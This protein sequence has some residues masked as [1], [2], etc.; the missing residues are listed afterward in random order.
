MAPHLPDD[1]ARILKPI[2]DLLPPRDAMSRLVVNG[3][4]DDP[5][6]HAALV[7]L[8]EEKIKATEIAANPPL[9]AGLWLYAD[10]L[11]RSH[12]VS[13]SI[14]T[15]TGSYWHAIMHRREGDFSNSK[16][17]YRRAGR[18]AVIS[19]IDPAGGGAGAGTDVGRFDPFEF[20]DR[21]ERAYQRGEVNQPEL[22]SLQRR[23]W[24]ALFEWCAER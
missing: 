18:H 20:V 13:Q 12:T 3:T 21:A 9:I 22:V 15:P 19:R 5:A 23:E 24:Q 1:L 17:W 8:I 14:D 7:A 6:D 16:Y 4:A 10:E 2:F 11:D